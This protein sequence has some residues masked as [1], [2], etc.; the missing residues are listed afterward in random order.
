V[1]KQTKLSFEEAILALDQIVTQLESE[2]L[3]LHSALE[4]F[5]QSQTL[6]QQCQSELQ[7]AEKQIVKVLQKNA[8]TADFELEAYT[9]K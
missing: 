7:Q 6:I 3:P 9:E 2:E 8:A 4:V 5:G 1:S